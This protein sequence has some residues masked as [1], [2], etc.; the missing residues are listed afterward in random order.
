MFNNIFL[1]QTLKLLNA[2]NDTVV[3]DKQFVGLFFHKLFTIISDK[4]YHKYFK[5]ET[6]NHGF[7]LDIVHI[8]LKSRWKI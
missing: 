4:Y 8:N 3:V 7:S 2:S 6:K 1:L 5:T